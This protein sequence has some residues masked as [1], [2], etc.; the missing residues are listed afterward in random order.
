[1]VLYSP[2]VALCVMKIVSTCKIVLVIPSKQREFGPLRFVLGQDK[3]LFKRELYFDAQFHKL[4][5]T[6]T[7]L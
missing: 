5:V 6:R 7:I 1:M 2:I 3:V 4:L